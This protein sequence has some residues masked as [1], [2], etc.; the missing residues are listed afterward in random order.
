M[1][2]PKTKAIRVTEK[3]Y[4]Y[5]SNLSEL[6]PADALT[7]IIDMI[8]NNDTVRTLIA[9]DIVMRLELVGKALQPKEPEAID[10]YDPSDYDP[11]LEPCYANA[12]YIRWRGDRE[13]SLELWGEYLDQC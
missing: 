1:S 5:L 9:G 11:K 2:K 4:D 13:D 8:T 6:N 12:Q 10:D 7:F 3:T